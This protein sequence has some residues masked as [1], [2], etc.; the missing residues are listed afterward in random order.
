MIRK[1]GLMIS[2]LAVLSLLA[3]PVL[4]QGT[5]LQG[6]DPN[7]DATA[8]EEEGYWYS[9]Y[10]LGN[11]VMRSGMGETFMPEMEM[12][13]QMIQM[14]DANPDDGNTAMPPLNAALLKAVYASGDPHYTQALNVDDF[15]TQRWN[16]ATFDTTVTSRAMGWTMIKETEWAKQFHVDDHFG[17]PSDDFGAQWRFVGLALNAEAKMQAQYALQMLKNE[18]GLIANSD[19][20]VDW[21]GQWV[22]L[23]AFSD[24]GNTLG[25]ANVPHS[26]TNR[27]ADPQASAMFLG[28]AD[29]LFGTLASRQPADTAELSLAIQGLTWY[30]ASTTNAN[31]QAQALTLITQ[32]GDDLVG[33][34]KDDATRK[35]YAVRGLIEAYRVTGDDKYLSAAADAFAGLVAEYDAAHGVFNSQDTYRIDDIAVIMGALNSLKLFGGSA[36]DQAKVEVIFTDFFQSAVWL[37]LCFSL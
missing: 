25:L 31:N 9:R 20:S 2:L 36:V 18:Q 6:G 17:T 12:V 15:G 8:A 23:T 14:A 7:F 13:Q 24:L 11:L 33:A 3:L 27:Y 19:G 10:N 26:A 32:Y 16:P 21:G 29:M 37:L 30:A 4:A 34:N 1:F 22:M 35:A 5:T 28:A